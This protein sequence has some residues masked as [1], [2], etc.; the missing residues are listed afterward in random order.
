NRWGDYSALSVDPADGCTFWYTS[1]YYTAASQAASLTGWLTRIG[2][3]RFPSCSSAPRGSLG[4]TITNC[5]SGLP[6]SGAV[7]QV[8]DGHSGASLANGTYSVGLAPGSYTA[9]ATGYGYNRTA[10]S[11]ISVSNGG[12]ATLN[13]CLGGTPVV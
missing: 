9:Y 11:S 10:S 4:G 2:S 13:A 12:T 1:E 6:I 5:S 3:F 8:S 7:M